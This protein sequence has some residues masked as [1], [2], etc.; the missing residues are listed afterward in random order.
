M[1][2][3]QNILDRIAQHKANGMIYNVDWN[4]LKSTVN[5]QLEKG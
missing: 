3:S 1:T 5:R 2:I 4:E